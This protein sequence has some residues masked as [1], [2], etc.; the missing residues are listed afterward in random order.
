MAKSAALPTDLKPR[1]ASGL[2]LAGLALAANWAGPLALA[3]LIGLIGILMAWEWGHVVRHTSFDPA[4]LVHAFTGAVATVLMATGNGAYALAATAVGAAS[5]A[6]ILRDRSAVIS[7]AG[8]IYTALPAA[9]LIWLRSSEPL[10]LVAVLFVFAIVWTTDTFSYVC[11]KLIGGPKMWPTVSP[12]K[13]W[14]GTVGGVLFAGAAAL[15]FPYVAAAGDVIYLPV[16][17]IVLAAAVQAGDL[18]ESAL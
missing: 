5:V 6:A 11:G 13:T 4:T 7:A 10:G 15:L 12:G 8:V 18:M 9:A 14:A 2:V 3:A 16:G 1:I 17:G